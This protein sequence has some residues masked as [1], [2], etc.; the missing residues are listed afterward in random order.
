[1]PFLF[2]QDMSRVTRDGLQNCLVFGNHYNHYAPMVGIHPTPQIA[3][4][5]NTPTNAWQVSIP[6]IVVACW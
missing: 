1:M 6:L 2:R 4:S 5:W 3:T